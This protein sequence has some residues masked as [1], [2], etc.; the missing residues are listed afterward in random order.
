MNAEHNNIDFD[1][2]D[3]AEAEGEE[4]EHDEE[5][6]AEIDEEGIILFLTCKIKI[7]YLNLPYFENNLLFSL[8]NMKF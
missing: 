6:E 5:W 7:S 1:N 4:G 2:I 3:S 8:N